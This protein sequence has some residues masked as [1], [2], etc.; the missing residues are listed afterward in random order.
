MHHIASHLQTFAC[1]GKS[2]CI[3]DDSYV[4]FLQETGLMEIL[5]PTRHYLIIDH[6]CNPSFPQTCG[7]NSEN[8]NCEFSKIKWQ[9]HSTVLWD[10]D[11]MCLLR[12]PMYECKTHQKWA[13]LSTH[14]PIL[15]P[16]T[17]TALWDSETDKPVPTILRRIGNSFVSDAAARFLFL[18]KFI[19]GGNGF[20]IRD[21]ARELYSSVAASVCR[22]LK[23]RIYSTNLDIPHDIRVILSAAVI[24]SQRF[25]PSDNFFKTLMLHDKAMYGELVTPISNWFYRIAK[26]CD[27]HVIRSDGS[28]STCL[29]VIATEQNTTHV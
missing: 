23:Q 21:L 9:Y 27:S 5:M 20:N 26:I 29:N 12:S 2:Q 25:L 22:K 14:K 1:V 24:Q 6:N 10:E 17:R 4:E 15:A 16:N 28:I 8:R 13:S 11:S 7:A 19:K 3:E 18:K